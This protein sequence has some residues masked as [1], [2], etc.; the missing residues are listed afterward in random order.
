MRLRAL[1]QRLRFGG[2]DPSRW[3]FD[4]EWLH[5]R[6]EE[7]VERAQRYEHSLTL[8]LFVFENL[9]EMAKSVGRHQT[10]VFL[11]KAAAVIRNQIRSPDVLAGYGKASI[12]VLMTETSKAAAV[13]AQLRV[14][15]AAVED[16]VRGGNGPTGALLLR[17]ATCPEDGDS[18]AGPHR[19]RESRL[20]PLRG[21]RH[22][23]KNRA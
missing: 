12:A 15:I 4:R 23:F 17:A 14:A 20:T 22:I 10:E 19:S 1:D 6:L 2:I 8:L 13:E 11:R 18:A 7:E 9:D 16:E 21:R 3:L 5:L